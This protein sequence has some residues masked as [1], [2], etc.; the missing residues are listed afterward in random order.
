LVFAI[1]VNA[2]A[3][4]AEIGEGWGYFYLQIYKNGIIAGL[5]RNSF[6]E[7]DTELSSI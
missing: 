6:I 4:S 2:F 1:I 5:T 3:Q 7:G